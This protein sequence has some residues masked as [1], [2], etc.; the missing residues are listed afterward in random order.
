MQGHSLTPLRLFSDVVKE[1]ALKD[2]YLEQERGYHFSNA[3]TVIVLSVSGANRMK[4]SFFCAISM[5]INRALESLDPVNQIIPRCFGAQG[6][7][8][9]V[10][11]MTTRSVLS[12]IEICEGP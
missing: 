4:S 10:L 1:A 12:L 6:F 3:S 7:S 8:Y 5:K 9:F 11:T 2:P